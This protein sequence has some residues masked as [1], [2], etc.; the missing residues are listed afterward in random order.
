MKN[1]DF[2]AAVLLIIGGLNWGLVGVFGIN[3]VG[4]LFAG[5]MIDT[6]IYAAVGLAA[7][8]QAYG[9]VRG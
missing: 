2:I 6:V 3:L 7:L 1:L 4:M 8:W 9:F 5:T